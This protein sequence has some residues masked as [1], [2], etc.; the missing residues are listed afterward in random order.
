MNTQQVKPPKEYNLFIYS[1]EIEIKKKKP[2]Q[3]LL[4]T[5]GKPRKSQ[6]DKEISVSN[7]INQHE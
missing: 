3:Y 2:I 6:P 7:K 4:Q 5:I 1:V